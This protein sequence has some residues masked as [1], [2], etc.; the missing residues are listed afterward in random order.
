MRHDDESVERGF[1]ELALLG[2]REHHP[3]PDVGAVEC[4]D[5]VEYGGRHEQRDARLLGVL[6]MAVPCQGCNSIA[7]G[8]VSANNG[9]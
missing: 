5:E 6:V 1:A 7:S 3:V 4:V 2:E 9:W 8:Q